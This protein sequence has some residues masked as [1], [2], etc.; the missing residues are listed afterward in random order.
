[1]IGEDRTKRSWQL[2]GCEDLGR[3]KHQVLP[4]VLCEG[5]WQEY[6]AI[7]GNTGLYQIGPPRSTH[8]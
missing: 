5:E 3:G 2:T 4:P 8:I 1:M 6:D 7:K